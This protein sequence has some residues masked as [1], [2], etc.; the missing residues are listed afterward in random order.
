MN[1]D[2]LN[3]VWATILSGGPIMVALLL[4]AFLLYRNVIGLFLFTNRLDA[5]SVFMEQSQDQS[6]GAIQ[7]FRDHL[8]QLVRTQLTYANV[9]IVA[10]PLLGLLGTVIGMLDTFKGIGAEAGQD[11]TKAVADGVKVA[12]ITTQTGL[13]IAIFGLFLTQLISRI[14]RSKDLQLLE[15]EIET[16]KRK[17]PQ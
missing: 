16:L 15:L 2:W 12:L 14:Y 5:R 7:D 13:M 6:H 4:L 8:S 1:I 9:L 3:T 11:T 17:L 10:A